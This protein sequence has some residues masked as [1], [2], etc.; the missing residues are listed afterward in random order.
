MFIVVAVVFNKLNMASSVESVAPFM[1]NE[2]F[3][4]VV[5][6]PAPIHKVDA[7]VNT[8]AVV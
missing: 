2:L 3:T 7:L 5:P 1:A 4:V 8:F 6:V